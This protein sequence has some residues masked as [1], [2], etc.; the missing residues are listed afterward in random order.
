MSSRETQRELDLQA[1]FGLSL[2]LTKGH[3]DRAHDALNR[4]LSLAETLRD[5]AYQ[6]RVLARL[7][8]Y[9]RRTGNIHQLFE[10]GK[11]AEMAARQVNEPIMIAAASSLLGVS[12]HLTGDQ[13]EGLKHVL[14][15]LLATLVQVGTRPSLVS[16][17]RV[18]TA[19]EGRSC[20]GALV[21]RI[22]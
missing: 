20:P 11:R 12:H 18:P 6:F 13:V 14:K 16:N 1:A 9:N 7:H 22:S 8:A 5:P 21:V 10:I 15:A 2:M 17:P 4:A 19:H 3:D